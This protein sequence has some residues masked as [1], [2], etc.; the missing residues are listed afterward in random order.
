MPDSRKEA[1][2]SVRRTHQGASD[3]HFPRSDERTEWHGYNQSLRDNRRQHMQHNRPSNPS[4]SETQFYDDKVPKS[5]HV[6]SGYHTFHESSPELYATPYAWGMGDEEEEEE[7][8]S[9]RMN[10]W[11]RRQQRDYSTRIYKQRPSSREIA[12]ST[13]L[14]SNIGPDTP[15]EM[16]RMYF[17]NSRRSGG[18]EMSEFE[19]D[20]LVARITFVDPKGMVT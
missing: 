5:D 11:K 17:E 9:N 3:E 4:Q 18:G 7:D 14:V 19:C 8:S 2:I 13:V 12:N 15:D 1:G 6:I 10:S 20:G 16:I